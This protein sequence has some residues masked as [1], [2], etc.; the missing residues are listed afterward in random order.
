ML[1]IVGIVAAIIAATALVASSVV[2][3]TSYRRL[4]AR[5]PLQVGSDGTLDSPGPRR[6]L[7]LAPALL[8]ITLLLPAL[9]TVRVAQGN[10]PLS[11]MLAYAG[12]G[13]LVG[14]ALAS[15]FLSANIVIV[16]RAALTGRSPEARRLAWM[17]R[18]FIASV[19]AFVAV[20]VWAA[21]VVAHS[22]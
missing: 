14:L 2:L 15:V 4:P 22:H 11:P 6:N 12:V 8:S 13:I 17:Y 1:V 7:W 16:V 10:S 21:F 18:V 19:Y 5:M 20:L 3:A 9:N